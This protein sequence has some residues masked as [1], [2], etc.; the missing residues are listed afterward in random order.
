MTRMDSH[1][2]VGTGS[3]VQKTRTVKEFSVFNMSTFL[4]QRQN[5]FLTR[6]QEIHDACSDINNYQLLA[7]C[8]SGFRHSYIIVKHALLEPNRKSLDKKIKEMQVLIEPFM[9]K[10]KGEI[11]ASEYYEIHGKLFD[12]IDELYYAQQMVNLGIPREKYKD[13]EQRL[14]EAASR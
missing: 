5:N 14:H 2:P 8:F 6:T 13:S 9:Y 10:T 3:Q 4:F 7:S 12:L 11:Q 1:E